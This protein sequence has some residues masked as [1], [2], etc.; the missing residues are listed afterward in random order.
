MV[1]IKY[2][3]ELIK[4]M[5]LFEKTTRAKL[6]D[7]FI[8]ENSVLNFIVAEGNLRNAVGKKGVVAKKLERMFNS[9]IKIVENNAEV[10]KFIRNYIY[11]LKVDSIELDDKIVV[12]MSKDTKTKG[13]LIG[14]NAKNLRYLEKVVNRY[15]DIDEIKVM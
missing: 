8:D 10:T 3:L 4:R 9:K 2:D 5:S 12:L 15:F 14:R 6:V 11:P 13:L 1:R 7:C